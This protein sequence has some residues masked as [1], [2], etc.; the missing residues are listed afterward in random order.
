MK[1]RRR[2]A[3]RI[4]SSVRPATV[5]KILSNAASNQLRRLGELWAF[6]GWNGRRS[7][8]C[9]LSCL[10]CFDSCIVT[11]RVLKLPTTLKRGWKGKRFI[12]E[13]LVE[14]FRLRSKMDYLD[15]VSVAITVLTLLHLRDHL[16]KGDPF[17]ANGIA[18]FRDGV[19][20]W[21]TIDLFW[22]SLETFD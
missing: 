18:H 2:F 14:F 17:Q 12:R 7:R 21:P 6:H 19:D 13:E 4:N 15:G 20:V 22:H 1:K 10:N 8:S 5:A 9:L 3:E 11:S 16:L